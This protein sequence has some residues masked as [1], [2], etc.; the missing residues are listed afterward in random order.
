MKRLAGVSSAIVLLAAVMANAQQPPI[1]TNVRA[2]IAKQDF[3]EAERLV[4]AHRAANG[5]TP[6]MLEALSWIGRGALAAKQ[7][8]KAEALA[9]QAYD[10]GVAALKGRTLDAEPHLPVAIGAAIEVLAKAAAERGA[11]ADAVSF[12]QREL[13]TFANTSIHTRIQKNLNL[14]SLEGTPAPELDLSEHIGKPPPTLASLKGKV[15]LQFF[16]AHWC[17]DCKAQGPVVASLMAKYASQ[18]LV[19]VAVDNTPGSVP[20]ETA[21]LPRDCLLLFG[22][23]GPGVT[24][25]ARAS[26][27]MTVSIAQFGSTRSI[28]AGVAAGIAMHSWIRRHAD[29]DT[30]W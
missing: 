22:Q 9:Q 8:P 27:S 14:L 4:A 18:G 7:G 21:E 15:T 24:D 2:A 3:G 19:V 12:L 20:I 26:A 1:I 28:N 13:A 10:L 16:W 17:S 5:V 11:R 29:I 23:E 25:S 30:A 6:P